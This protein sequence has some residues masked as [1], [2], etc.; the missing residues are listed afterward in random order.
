MPITVLFLTRTYPLTPS[1]SGILQAAAVAL[2]RQTCAPAALISC[3]VQ[4][5][6]APHPLAAARASRPRLAR[7]LR[8]L[9]TGESGG[10]REGGRERRENE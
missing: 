7:A 1:F 5:T 4:I 6:P 9:A 3:A 8:T 2:Q 10:R